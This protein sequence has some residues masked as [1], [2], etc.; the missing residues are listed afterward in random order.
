MKLK[1]LLNLLRVV[2]TAAMLAWLSTNVD[3]QNVGRVLAEADMVLLLPAVVMY[4]LSI[5]CAAWR[6]QQLLE[7]MNIA[8][9]L[10]KLLRLVFVGAFF[11]M[12]LPS[13][14]GGDLMKMVLLAPD[15]ERREA[16]IASV[17]M[18]RVVG[19]AVTIG[20][21]LVAVLL[22]PNVWNDVGLLATLAI[23]LFG[24]ALGAASLFSK[25]LFQLVARL[26]PG[27]IWRR[28]GPLALR[29]H[30]AL[31]CLSHRPDV[32]LKA[33]GVSVL[34][35]LA[36][37]LSAYCAGLAFGIPLSPIA[38][39]ATVP[40]ALAITALPLAINGLGLQDNALVFLLGVV[41]VT[42]AQALGLSIYLHAMRN[43]MGLVG[44]VIFAVSRGGAAR[45][46]PAPVAGD[47]APEAGVKAELS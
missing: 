19:L 34:R 45:E 37:C 22:L 44:G 31:L 25:R 5:F 40:I 21:G 41:G 24:F 38:Y 14:V 27:F 47:V 28:V 16:A 4:L 26:T 7:G 1:P 35:Q 23:A 13:S 8:L 32:L 6:W 42:A 46:I 9:S 33:S 29:V 39:F 10:L 36:I 3:M 11:N 2:L 18:D 15:L 20:V 30:E 17:L 12:F 43:G